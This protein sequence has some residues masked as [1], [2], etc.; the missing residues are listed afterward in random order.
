MSSTRTPGAARPRPLP[1][2]A[3]IRPA[4]SVPCR[5]ARTAAA[6]HEALAQPGRHEAGELGVVDVDAAV[7]HGH[8]H[9]R[10]RGHEVARDAEGIGGD[11]VRAQVPLAG[12][13]QGVVRLV[14]QG[15]EPPDGLRV[16]FQQRLLRRRGRRR[17]VR[18]AEPLHLGRQRRRVRC[19][20]PRRVPPRR[21]CGRRSGTRT[22][23]GPASRAA[24]GPCRR[25]VRPRRP[26]KVTFLTRPDGVSACL[27]VRTSPPRPTA[28]PRASR[29][30]F[31]GFQR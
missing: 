20:S 16:R 10:R 11:A 30:N 7:D 8:A 26:L 18:G 31:C 15:G 9:E 2:R 17:G 28:R 13:E 29:V 6:G 22:S 4:T 25:S 5:L 1:V 14:R 24:R 27:I 23:A 21:A 19:G 12:R 3:A